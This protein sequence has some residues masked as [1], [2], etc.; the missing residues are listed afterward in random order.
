MIR[1]TVRIHEL[2]CY[3]SALQNGVRGAGTTSALSYHCDSWLH[4][5]N[6]THLR[7]YRDSCM[8]LRKRSAAPANTTAV[9]PGRRRGIDTALC[10]AAKT[11]THPSTRRH[12]LLSNDRHGQGLVWDTDADTPLGRALQNDCP[13]RPC[14]AERHIAVRS[15][16]SPTRSAA[17][18]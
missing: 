3:W 11:N 18:L 12:Q 9:F 13:T 7:R 4:F 2:R 8:A 14:V 10:C 17:A 1:L 16:C 5:S 15:A 6:T